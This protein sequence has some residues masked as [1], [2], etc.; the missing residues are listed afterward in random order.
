MAHNRT[1]LS[2]NR[3]IEF[4]VYQLVFYRREALFISVFRFCQIQSQST[5]ETKR[6]KIGLGR[7]REVSS[8]NFVES[9]LFAARSKKLYYFDF[10]SDA[11]YGTLCFLDRR[12]VQLG[13]PLLYANTHHSSRLAIFA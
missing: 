9:S 5:L 11:L 6:T 12:R 7:G 1:S 3:L 4:F 13:R 8:L 2:P 10:L